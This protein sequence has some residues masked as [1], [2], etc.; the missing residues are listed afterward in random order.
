VEG[1]KDQ[2]MKKYIMCLFTLVVLF[3]TVI[4]QISDHKTLPNPDFREPFLEINS[5]KF[6]QIK[7]VVWLDNY[8]ISENAVLILATNN[9]DN[10]SYSSLSYLNVATGESQLLA[11]FPTHQYLN[12]VIMF[13][14]PFSQNDIIT[15]FKGGIVKTKITRDND[16]NLHADQEY[17]TIDGFEE[18]DSMEFKGNLYYSKTND[19]LL[20]VKNF[21]GTPYHFF[22][23]NKKPVTDMTY[24]RKPYKIINANVL[25]RTLTYTSISKNGIDL[26]AMD[27]DGTPLT[28]YNK[29]LIKN[30]VKAQTIEDRFGFIGMNLIT[31]PSSPFDEQALNIFMARR[32]RSDSN[33]ILEL[34]TIPFNTDPQGALPAMDSTTFNEDYTVVYTSYDENHSGKLNICNYQQEPKVILED[35]NLFGPVSITRKRILDST[36]PL[37]KGDIRNKYILYFTLE[38]DQ[39]R[40]RICDEHGTLVQDLTTMIMS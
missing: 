4:T 7:N 34:D 27:L 37:G 8:V 36:D 24:L 39:V 22:E 29:P 9:K 13:D 18:A 20:Y 15:P 11:E 5:S 12:D 23:S 19:N 26:Y 30:V 35:E 21:D 38:N 40:I 28:K 31:N 1:V 32:H 14:N 17:L 25:D 2:V 3:A 16:Q 10:S 6:G 33:E